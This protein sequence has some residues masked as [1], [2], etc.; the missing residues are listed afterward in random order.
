MRT[1]R[2]LRCLAFS[3][4]A[5][6]LGC[7][8]SD[9]DQPAA[10]PVAD[11]GS[12]TDAAGDGSESSHGDKIEIDALPS[13]IPP[14]VVFTQAG[15]SA[16]MSDN[17][18]QNPDCESVQAAALQAW[19]AYES[20][21]VAA[22]G[23]G[24]SG[25]AIK[26]VRAQGDT[27]NHGAYQTVQ[28]NQTAPRPVYFSGWSKATDV[29]GDPDSA[30]SIYLDISYVS[31]AEDPQNGCEKTADE[32][33]S[34]YGQIPDPRF[35]TGTH[36]WQHR[37][38]FAVPAY[39][40]KQVGFYVLLRGDHSGTVL[41]D[42]LELKEVDAGILT[43]D[44]QLVSTQKPSTPYAGGEPLTLATGDGLGLSIAAHGVVAQSLMLDGADILHKEFD[45]GSGFIVHEADADTWWAVGGSAGKGPLEGNPGSVVQQ[46]A[47]T[48]LDLTFQA[49]WEPSADRIRIRA[50]VSSTK[51]VDRA[52]TLYFA[53]PME[54]AGWSWGDDI[55]R[56][57]PIGKIDEL[58]N[59]TS[60]WGTGDLGA[61]GKFS[62]YPFGTVYSADRGL[63]I[64][65]PLDQTRIARLVHNPVTR[66]LYAAFDLGISADTVKF[67]SKASAEIVLYRTSHGSAQE[68]FRSALQ[69]FQDRF[70]EHFVRRIP[71]AEEGI[72]VAFADLSQMVHG[73]GESVE[74][75]HVGVHEIGGVSQVG[76]DDQHGI[77]SL[78]YIMEPA[79][80]WLQIK[81]SAV[82]PNDKA[83]VV[84]YLQKLYQSGTEQEKREAEKTLSSSI[85]DR[86][87]TMAYDPYTSGPPWC[88][89][90]CALF[91]LSPDPDIQEAPYTVNQATFYWNAEAKGA[92][93]S[94]PGLDGE[95]LDSF[96]MEAKRG[97]FRRSHFAAADIPLTFTKELPRAV[98][99]PV[100]F[101]TLELT[102]WLRPQIPLGKFL[103]ANGMLIG[104]PWGAELFDYMGQEIDWIEDVGGQWQ[105]VPEDDWLLSYR[106]SMAGQRPYGFLMNTNFDNMSNAMVERYMQI[107]LFYG[108]YPS[109]FS[110]NA[111]E[112]NY[113]E[114][115]ALYGRDRALFKKYIPMIRTLN[116]GGWRPL[117]L[118]S[119]SVDTVY[120]ERFGQSP[121]SLRFTL[122][123]TSDQAQ[124]ATVS[125]DRARLGIP[126][127]FTVKSMLLGSPDVAVA[128][129]ASSFEVSL[130]AGEI[131]AVEVQ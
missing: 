117:T 10:Q 83:Q 66:Q 91:Y 104:V 46:S 11:G 53:L 127:A 36:D 79:S 61:T 13:G 16:P 128:A 106:R 60:F 27:A 8:G 95:Y 26:L 109:M 43:F 87:G 103:I 18:L 67:P 112:G 130:P 1:S 125:V 19:T 31:K 42:D 15:T 57:R 51:A 72:W 89:G 74:D 113:F 101:S 81:D 3:T 105:V 70:P 59:L 28:L 92:Y 108:I 21:Y 97:D 68:G 23:E 37:E 33:C 94:T 107:C 80:T 126:G 20:G 54:T 64:G 65:M 124:T 56:S 88:S 7:G 131:E 121:S 93:S 38:G 39:P 9:N 17:K 34:L 63:A 102:R 116:E 47:L 58:S 78:R 111:S 52:L 69:G 5:A 115:Q 100:I 114:T 49:T 48:A 86:D 122:R 119:T 85:Y 41:Y 30:S 29:T 98:I 14:W 40:I 4:A 62:R 71:P 123:N 129:G 76:F 2:S 96:V 75:F 35:D 82:D 32:S 99:T 50:E 90:P 6:C 118:A 110:H 12:G 44:G 73:A 22:I 45:Y 25:N 120:L 84:A 24:H 55:R 77:R